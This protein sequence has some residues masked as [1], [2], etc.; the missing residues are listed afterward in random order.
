MPTP[1]KCPQGQATFAVPPGH[2]NP[3]GHRLQLLDAASEVEP[4]GQASFAPLPLHALPEGHSEHA[5][6]PV[7]NE[8]IAQVLHVDEP[9]A[10]ANLPASQAVHAVAAAVELNCPAGHEV[11]FSSFG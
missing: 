7:V 5:V 1:L 11:H 4:G 2:S 10:A 6:V 9:L 3:A 8:P